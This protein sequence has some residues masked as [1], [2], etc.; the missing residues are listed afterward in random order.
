M[1]VQ[2]KSGEPSH[3]FCVC[4]SKNGEC[5]SRLVPADA[6]FFDELLVVSMFGDLDHDF[7]FGFPDLITNN[8]FL[9]LFF[10]AQTS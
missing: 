1:L 9:S 5:K 7:K 10:E 2:V 6:I 3:S 4:P 8:Y